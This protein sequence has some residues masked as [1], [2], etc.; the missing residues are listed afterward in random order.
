[1]RI[2]ALSA[3]EVGRPAN[4]LAL[5]I[6]ECTAETGIGVN[7][8]YDAIRTGALKARKLGRKTII[9]R[10]DLERWLASL[11]VLDLSN[12]PST[13]AVRNRNPIGRRKRVVEGVAV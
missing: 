12:N 3:E 2:A 5:S 9:L 13:P 1:M 11:P 8:L 4:G 6:R 7:A 10:T